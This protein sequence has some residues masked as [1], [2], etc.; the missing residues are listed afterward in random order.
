M[1]NYFIVGVSIIIVANLFVFS[2]V[3]SNR[4]LGEKITLTLSERE[5]RVPYYGI[6]K[7]DSSLTFNINWRLKYEGESLYRYNRKLKVSPQRIEELGFNVPKSL[8]DSRRI[9]PV[10]EERYW[11]VE[12]NGKTYQQAINAAEER[13]KSAQI[14]LKDSDEKNELKTLKRNLEEERNNSSRLFVVDVA[15][16]PEKLDLSR[17][18]SQYFIARGLVKPAVE[19]NYD[20]KINKDVFTYYLYFK[21]L[22]TAN[23]YVPLVHA[24]NVREQLKQNKREKLNY[25]VDVNWGSRFEPWVG[26]FVLKSL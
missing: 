25:Q 5:L 8:G 20:K 16:Q 13:L 3:L 10:Y 7:E 18:G 15:E 26:G 21:E 22:S 12:F 24:Q 19:K 4:S 6:R 9:D 17:A 23:I 14:K 2:N 11:L 1:R